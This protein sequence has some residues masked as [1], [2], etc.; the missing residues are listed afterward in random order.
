MK[1]IYF[2]CL[3]VLMIFN[4]Y[5]QPVELSE[6]KKYALDFMEQVNNNKRNTYKINTV[7]TEKQND[8]N[9]L[10]IIN[11]KDGGF[12]I[13][14]ANKKAKPVLAY[15]E[16]SEIP[17][18][19]KQFVNFRDWIQMYNENITEIASD[20]SLEPVEK[21]WKEASVTH[22]S[23]DDEVEPLITTTWG[24]SNGYN[25]Y[26]PE[27]V[28]VG[29]VATAMA[30]V[31]NYYEYPD[32]GEAWHNYEHPD[33]G[34]QKAIFD[35]VYYQWNDMPDVTSSDAI[36]KLM[37]H[38]A[39]SVD[40]NFAPEGSGAYDRDVPL[41]LANYFRYKQSIDF[42]KK[43]EYSET[44]WKDLL[45]DELTAARPVIYSGSG[46][47]GGHA[48][49]CD[50]Y[51]ADGKFHFNWGWEGYADGYYEIGQLNPGDS[52]FN[53]NNSATIGIEPANG[54][55]NFYFVKKFSDFPYTS[56]YPG[57]IDGVSDN[58]AWA[59]GNDGSGDGQ[60]LKIFTRTT[61]G[62][63]TWDGREIEGNADD[64]AMINGLNRDTAFIAAFG[65]DSDNTILKTTDGGQNWT[66][67]LNGAGSSSFFNVVHFFDE[68]NGF[69]QGDPEGGE[70]E[71]YVT[72]DGGDNWERIDGANIPDPNPSDEYG[73]V[74]HYT[75]V[76]DTIWY[77][78]NSGRVYK[79]EDKGYNWDVYNIYTGEYNTSIDIAFDDGGKNGIAHVSL[80]DGSENQGHKLYNSVDG[81]E[82]WT[83]LDSYSGNF[84]RSGISSIPGLS[85]TFVSVGADH[86][87][88]KMGVSYTE[89]GGETWIDYTEYYKNLQ[90]ISVDFVSAGRGY[91][92]GFQE[93]YRGGAFVFGIPLAELKAGFIA[94]NENGED[95]AFCITE[96]L[97]FTDHSTGYIESYEWDFG[98]SANPSI[99]T[100][101]G[102][103]IISYNTK[104]TK[105][106][107][108]TV[109]DS[110]RTDIYSKKIWI[111]S[112]PPNPIDTVTGAR[113]IDLTNQ[114]E[115]TE[116][117]TAP[118][119]EYVNY[120]WEVPNS[121][122]WQ[123]DS[124]TNS[125]DIT[126]SGS[127]DTGKIYVEVFNACGSEEYDFEVETVDE[128][129]GIE[130]SEKNNIKI[131]PVPATDYINIENAQ[132]ATVTI[133][134]MES[135]AKDTYN[136]QRSRE[137][138]NLSGYEPGLYY[139]KIILEDEVFTKKILIVN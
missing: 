134:D 115:V 8:N 50:G 43:S 39:V 47:D 64:F 120:A 94:E 92:G 101:V 69:V 22:K 57:Y 96:E 9:T 35:T 16:T 99:A 1:K 40:M 121:N 128:T 15:S 98:E 102:P 76:E 129:Y 116:T 60:N 103:H 11:L 74:G 36:A 24:Q 42:V 55:E 107:T 27:D 20:E 77:T 61:D 63:S 53:E 132:Y 95:T 82:T 31:M 89:D 139:F 68:N 91:A 85:N 25:D 51:D 28:P 10:Y 72:T 113:L 135:R 46:D 59:V 133:Y 52:E 12:V 105:E 100:G 14:A 104:G 2:F 56:A 138:I 70:F 4:S 118:Y 114:E 111:D 17:E 71:L 62:G 131:Y 30:Q 73:I 23:A 5:G 112:L 83:E 13:M 32:I 110:V 44:E 37:Y 93:N 29:C 87:T 21:A 3:A 48:F 90:F 136:I 122:I 38:C 6:A 130:S 66:E 124:D 34:F 26:A 75:A 33:Y 137:R 119:M 7:F 123:G 78:T 49:V 18:N 97:T 54:E 58:V 88:P 81:G 108:L 125:I 19:Y 86:E 127:P 67:V 117:Y 45:R 80:T 41:S 65:S 126:F 109:E 79:S 106:I 84:Y